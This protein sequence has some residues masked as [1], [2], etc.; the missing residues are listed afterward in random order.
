MR[1]HLIA[2]RSTGFARFDVLD[3]ERNKRAGHVLQ[4]TPGSVFR[5][6]WLGVFLTA[7]KFVHTNDSATPLRDV[8]A[9]IVG[10][11]RP[12]ETERYAPVM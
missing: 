10:I 9:H 3:S 7:A 6:R 1:K 8:P 11:T 5:T 2:V 12:P 4:D